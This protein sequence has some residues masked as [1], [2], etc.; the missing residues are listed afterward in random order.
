[1]DVCR[2]KVAGKLAPLLGDAAARQLEVHVF[3]YTVR[4]LRDQKVPCVWDNPKFRYRYTTKAW[5]MIFNLSN[6]KNPGLLA[7]V[8]AGSCLKK[9]VHSSPAEMFPELW[10]P[11]YDEVARKQLRKQLTQDID[12]VPDGAEAC[13][14]CKSRKTVYY[15]MQTR[16]AD[17]P[18][19]NF[20]QCLACSKRWKS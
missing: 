19:T 14:K 16:S 17:E 4:S 7:R 6:P 2:A 18:M 5:S 1:M 11:I 9:L 8:R 20:F 12:S 10:E 3:N 15:Q 13:G